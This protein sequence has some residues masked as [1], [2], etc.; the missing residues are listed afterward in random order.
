MFKKLFVVGVAALLA[1]CGGGGGGGGGDAGTGGGMVGVWVDTKYPDT[2]RIVIDTRGQF[3]TLSVDSLVNPTY[4]VVGNGIISDDGTTVSAAGY[5]TVVSQYTIAGAYLKA[6]GSYTGNTAHL[7]VEDGFNGT[8]S[9]SLSRLA[10]TSTTGAIPTG[11]YSTYAGFIVFNGASG[12]RISPAISVNGNRISGVSEGCSWSGSLKDTGH[13][14][15]EVTITF[16]NSSNCLAPGK[17]ASGVAGYGDGRLI[18]MLRLDADFRTMF[19]VV[20]Q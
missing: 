20:A 1:A 11:V 14:F 18:T 15:S 8:N 5:N 3:W 13:G 6:G 2:G 4:A 9:Y 16:S 12:Y 17:T 7:T 19:L 10:E